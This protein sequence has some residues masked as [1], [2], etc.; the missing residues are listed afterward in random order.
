[1]TLSTM[2]LNAT[3]MPPPHLTSAKTKSW[4]QKPGLHTIDII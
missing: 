3:L 1:L 2:K 4:F